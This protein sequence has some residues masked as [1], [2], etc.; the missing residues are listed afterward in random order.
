MVQEMRLFRVAWDR[1][2]D[3][4]HTEVIMDLGIIR[5]NQ[6]TRIVDGGS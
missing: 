1:V 2:Q 4:G 5:M 3:L 6:T